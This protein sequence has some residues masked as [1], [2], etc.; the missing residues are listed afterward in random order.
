M[1]DKQF[2]EL[3]FVSDQ[4]YCGRGFKAIYEQVRCNNYYPLPSP[5]SPIP[6]IQ[7]PSPPYPQPQP[8]PQP[9]PNPPQPAPCGGDITEETFTL[10][11]DN[12][13]EK[14]CEYNIIKWSAVSSLQLPF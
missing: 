4:Q 1:E 7:P 13:L 5:E 6:P 3:Q 12:N 11:I 14:T 10:H 2:I 8:Q 9:Q